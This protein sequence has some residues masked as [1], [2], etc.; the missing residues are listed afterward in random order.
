MVGA[1][2]ARITIMIAAEVAPGTDLP[3]AALP[4]TRSNN[5]LAKM[6]KVAQIGE[7]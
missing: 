5:S 6:A 4:E 3:A 7:I 1:R 2:V